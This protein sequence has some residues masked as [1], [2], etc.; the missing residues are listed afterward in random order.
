MPSHFD[1]NLS[2]NINL[3]SA[4]KIVVNGVD[5]DTKHVGINASTRSLIDSIGLDDVI[6]ALSLSDIARVRGPELELHYGSPS[7]VTI[8]KST[9]E[10]ASDEARTASISKANKAESSGQRN[11]LAAELEGKKLPSVQG[12]LSMNENTQKA[13]PP[14][15][16]PV[17]VGTPITPSTKP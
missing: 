1:P 6:S 17:V 5:I 14:T 9:I 7:K 16:K 3:T 2:R 12:D 15:T 11:L 10:R 13:E 8:A 4:T